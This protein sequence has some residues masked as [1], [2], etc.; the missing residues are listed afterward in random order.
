MEERRRADFL[1]VI[2]NLRRDVANRFKIPYMHELVFDNTLYQQYDISLKDF[3]CSFKF[4]SYDKLRLESLFITDSIIS[5]RNKTY[6]EIGVT[7]NNFQFLSPLQ[8]RIRYSKPKE[9]GLK[10]VLGPIKERIWWYYSEGDPGSLCDDGYYNYDGL[11]IM[12]PVTTTATK[13]L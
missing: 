9:G 13:V 8:K 3:A 11:C 4:R 7:E 1:S 6:Y 10:C 12:I 5:S 2:N